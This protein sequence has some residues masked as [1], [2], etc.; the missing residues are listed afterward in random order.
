MKTT[1]RRLFEKFHLS[2]GEDDWLFVG[3]ENAR[4]SIQGEAADRYVTLSLSDHAKI[5]LAA[6]KMC[7]KTG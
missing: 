3:N 5:A 6:A 7:M 1:R 4:R 2:T